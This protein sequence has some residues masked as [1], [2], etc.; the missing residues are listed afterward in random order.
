VRKIYGL[1]D[2][3]AGE[4]VQMPNFAVAAGSLQ[5]LA[6]QVSRCANLPAVNGGVQLHA[7]LQRMEERLV[8]MERRMEERFDGLDAQLSQLRREATVE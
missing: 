1:Y 4:V 5:T 6:D 8:I 3:D 2:M 7:V